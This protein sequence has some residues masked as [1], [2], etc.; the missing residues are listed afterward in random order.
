MAKYVLPPV[1]L[2]YSGRLL[3]GVD[4]VGR[5]PLAGDVVACAV[6]LD[7]DRPIPGLRDSKALTEARREAL[8]EEIKAGALAWSL[9]RCSVEEID[10]LNILQASMLAMWRAVDGLAL[11][12]EFV[13]VDGNR[14]PKWTYSAQAVVKGDARVEVISAASIIAKVTRDQELVAL[15]QAYPG[16][17]FDVHKGY[18]TPQHLAALAKL[19]PCAAHRRSFAPVRRLLQEPEQ[20]GLAI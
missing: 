15:G 2:N 11:R 14:L 18:P 7:P 4:E 8:A 17:G 13:A 1:E 5:G 16:Y 20:K 10:R 12:P 3:A 6:M 9:G 19:G